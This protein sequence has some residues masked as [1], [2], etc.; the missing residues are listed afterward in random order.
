MGEAPDS[1]SYVMVAWRTKDGR[2][3]SFM[4]DEAINERVAALS[5][6]KGKYPPI[7]PKKWRKAREAG[8]GRSSR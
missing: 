3:V 2:L 4:S 5:D 6:I 8:H 1:G 7:M